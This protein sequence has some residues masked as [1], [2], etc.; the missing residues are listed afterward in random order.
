M[1]FF[2]LIS[3]FFS[4]SWSYIIG[5]IFVAGL[6][7]AGYKYVHDKDLEIEKL[8]TDVA[9][10]QVVINQQNNNITVLKNGIELLK[11]EV[12]AREREQKLLSEHNQMLRDSNSLITREL[13]EKEKK[14]AYHDLLKLRNGKKGEQ[15]LG[16]IN[17]SV[18]RQYEEFS[19]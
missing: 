4:G 19:K 16:V 10:S 8:R 13:G 3:S 18:R 5:G 6:V 11:G 14:L 1:P 12:A 15:V 7:F 17:N 9:N 2:S